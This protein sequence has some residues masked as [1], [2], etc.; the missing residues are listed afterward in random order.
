MI[1]TR[2]ATLDDLESM[3]SVYTAAWREGFKHMFSADIFVAEDFAAQRAAECHQE[4]VNDTT[5]TFVV[6]NGSMVIGFAAVEVEQAG[7]ELHDIWLHPHAW[8]TSGASALVATVEEEVRSI[9]AARVTAWV[10]EDS[11][12]GRRFFDKLGWRPTGAFEPLNLYPH[13]PNRLFEYERVLAEIDMTRGM[14]RP[15]ADLHA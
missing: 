11:P 3:V 8:G 2:R 5:D 15:N 13:Q 1:Q 4:L 14:P 6:E 9:G 7:A 10:P 12:R